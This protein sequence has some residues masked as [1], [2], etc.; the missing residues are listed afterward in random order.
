MSEIATSRV[1]KG[2]PQG[3]P[4]TPTQLD[5]DLAFPLLDNFSLDFKEYGHIW[6]QI[7][8]QTKGII[9]KNPQIR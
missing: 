2:V 4:L 5:L 7:K 9:I 1:H 6:G 3:E 8:E